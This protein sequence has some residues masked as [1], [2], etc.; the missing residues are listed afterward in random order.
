M[1]A[2]LEYYQNGDGNVMIP[3]AL[4]PYMNGLEQITGHTPIGESAV[5][6]GARQ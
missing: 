2:I 3:E 4:Q 6:A 1:V 5:G